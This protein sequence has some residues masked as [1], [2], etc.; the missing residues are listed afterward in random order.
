MSTAYERLRDALTDNGSTVKESGTDKLIAQCPAHPDRSPSLSVTGIE[1]SALLYCHAGCQAADVLAALNM[2]MADLFDNKRDTTYAYPGGRKVRRRPDK[3]F[4]QSGNKADRSLFRSDR[5]ADADHV[6]VVE[7]EKDVLA[8]EAI[9]AAA[10]CSAMGAGKAHLADWD[11]LRGKHV[12]VVPDDDEAGHKH[13]AQVI[14]KLRAVGVASVRTARVAVGKDLADHIAAGKTLADL[15]PVEKAAATAVTLDEAHAIFRK[16]LG[17]DYDLDALNVMLATAAAERFDDGSDPVWLL[18]VGGPGNAKTETVQA[19]DG[20][21]AIVTSSISSE[22]ALLSATPKRERT[23]NATGGLLRKL[24]DRGVLIVKDV[25]TILSMNR[26][27]RANVLAALREIYDGRWY[28]EVGTDGGQTMEWRGRIAVIGAVT[29]AWDTAHAVVSSMG[30]RFVLVRLDST[31][32]R[33]L[34]GRKAIGN[35]GSEQAMRAEL[36]A[37]VAG[38]IAGMDTDPGDITETE[39]NVLLAAADLVT[40][41]RTGVEFDYRGDVIDAHAPEMPTRFAKQLTQIVRGAVA[42]GMTR[43]EA[44]RLAI[45]CARDSMPP[46]RLAIIDDVAKNPAAATPDVRKRID[47]PRNTVDRQLQALHMLGVLTVD[48][49][50]YGSEGRVRWFYTLSEGIDPDS[51]KPDQCVPEMSVHIPIPC[52]SEAESPVLGSDKSGT[53]GGPTGCRYC[54]APLAA[55]MRSQNSRGYCNRPACI[56]SANGGAA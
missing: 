5:L 54:G 32:G 33:Q 9:G 48:E 19:C 25:T 12:T 50:E 40:L 41:A 17:E 14:D 15:V 43:S 47:K 1:G 34:A 46:M 30:D 27:Q 22:A 52:K 24:G 8:A 35:T 7:G 51:L 29:T 3:Q 2:T 20:I 10:V 4:P 42:V 18:I 38:V 23:K 13:A 53:V 55:H 11:T 45:R 26:D 56:E 37:A 39:T 28:R 36:A 6:L 31:K 49:V 16:W 44:L 21:G